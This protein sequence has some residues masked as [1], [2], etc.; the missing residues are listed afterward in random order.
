[1]G[2]FVWSDSSCVYG[3]LTTSLRICANSDCPSGQSEKTDT[4][5]EICHRPRINMGFLPNES[6]LAKFL[7]KQKS[8]HV[9]VNISGR[10]WPAF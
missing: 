6:S 2:L 1:M 10:K 8:P 9:P 4:R 5:I 7:I 3:D